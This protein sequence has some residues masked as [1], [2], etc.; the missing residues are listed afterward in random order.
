MVFSLAGHRF[1]SSFWYEGV[2]LEDLSQRFGAEF[3]ERIFFHIAAFELNKLVSLAPEAV[4]FGTYQRFQT[5]R[6]ERLWSTIL[7]NV[8]A[9]WRF[10]NDLPEYRC[11]RFIS[12]SGADFAAPATL[13]AGEVEN[14]VFCGGGK[15]SLVSLSLLNRGGLA[16]DT[17]A[18]SASVYGRPEPQ[19]HW[20]DGLVDC[21]PVRR[22]RR[23]WMFEDFL[24]SPVLRLCPQFGISTLTAAETPGSVFASLP[25]ALQHG[26]RNLIVGHERSADTGQLVWPL[27]GEEINHQ[28][29]K[30]SA[31]EEL[32]REYVRRE[33]IAGLR[34]F[35]IL[36]PIYDVV[37]FNLLKSDLSS[38]PL[39]HSCNQSK[40]W[41]RRCPKC[42]YVWLNYMAYLPRET[43]EKAF[44]DENLFDF[45]E[46]LLGFRQL[47]GIESRQP[48]ECIGQVGEVQ[49]ALEL[50]RRKGMRGRALEAFSDEVL[51]IST[52]P[53]IERYL[54]VQ[55]EASAIPESIAR[56]VIPIMRDCAAK[57]NRRLR[58]LLG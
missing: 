54:T 24:E 31:A 58:R 2:D 27:T 50:C 35:S 43:V 57:T 53:L 34:Y 36:K 51:P 38:V 10:E 48:F 21:F 20:I 26:Y 17:F 32:I 47:M 45:P 42:A 33:L 3:L 9:Q 56:V 16:F 11:P 25:Y 8:W 29:G 19:H 15:D 22:R 18:Y 7:E 4:D 1:C 41:C 28:W 46:N 30:S 44:G 52:A 12:D 5:P 6:F 14:L 49:L 39:A 13:A 40:P 23:L 37:I 55:T